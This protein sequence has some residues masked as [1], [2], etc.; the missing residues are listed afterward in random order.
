MSST[1]THFKNAPLVD[2]VVELR[3][4]TSMPSQV[5]AGLLYNSLMSEGYDEFEELPIA[6]LPAE[7]RDGDI[8]LRY[9]AHYR[10]KSDKY[11]V[12]V[13]QRVIAVAAICY[14]DNEY[15]GWVDYKKEI[16][17]V[18]EKVKELG[19]TSKFSRIDVRY[20]NLFQ[21]EDVSDRLNIAIEVPYKENLAKEKSAGFIYNYDGM[22]TRVNFATNASMTFG[23][24]EISLSGAILDIDTSIE[25]EVQFDSVDGFIENGHAYTEST[26]LSL[27]EG[28]LLKELKGEDEQ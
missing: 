10:I 4:D 12:S 21:S 2:T 28:S 14:G 19:V 23:N 13:S 20:I 11:L 24:N 27:L 18:L 7:I 3:F 17:K 26:F 5:V 1:T 6:Q 16:L 9:N 15:P 22:Q 8:N 25:E